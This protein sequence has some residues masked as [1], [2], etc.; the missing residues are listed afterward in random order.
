MV[1]NYKK[2]TLNVWNVQQ[3]MFEYKTLQDHNDSASEDDY[4]SKLKRSAT[5]SAVT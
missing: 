3:K 5:F 2:K 1:E 4:K